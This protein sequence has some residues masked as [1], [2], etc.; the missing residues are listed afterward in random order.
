MRRLYSLVGLPTLPAWIKRSLVF[1]V[2]VFLGIAVITWTIEV[3]QRMSNRD[4]I[5]VYA[6][7]RLN[8][9]LH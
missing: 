9:S 5:D 1:R 3:A 6:R 4:D 7:D 2:F 8:N